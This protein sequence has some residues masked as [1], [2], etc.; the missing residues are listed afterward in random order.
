MPEAAEFEAY[1][2]R[3]Q[4]ER[5]ARRAAE[6][7]LEAKA[8]ELYD[9]NA[10][11]EAQVA[12]RT[13]DLVAA[14]DAAMAA[15]QARNG[16]F[17]R[18][19]HEI[20]TPMNAVIGMTDCMLLEDPPPSIFEGLT[21]VRSASQSLLSIINDI[22]DFSKIEA[23]GLSLQP[24]DFDLGAQFTSVT[25][26]L[27]TSAE[28]KGLSLAL[29]VDPRLNRHVHG[30]E[31]QLRQVLL[32]LVGNAIKFTGTGEVELGAHLMED[33][34]ATLAVE[35]WV[36]DTGSGI[37]EEDCG[38][39]FRAFEQVDG[40][41]TRAHGGT[42]LGLAICQSLVE[43]LGGEIWVESTLGEG[44]TFRF[45]ATLAAEG[46][47]RPVQLPPWRVLAL[48]SEPDTGDIVATALEG[49]AVTVAIEHNEMDV[50]Q[51]L[52]TAVAQGGAFDVVL[53][54]AQGL[55]AVSNLTAALSA[56]PTLQGV[57]TVVVGPSAARLEASG[58]QP[59]VS[60]VGTFDVRHIRTGLEELRDRTPQA[61]IAEPSE[62]LRRPARILVVDDN[63]TN[64]L[65][66]T[67]LLQR[68]G[69]IVQTAENGRDAVER[70]ACNRYDLVLMDVQMPGISGI[71]AARRI[72]NVE[73]GNGDGCKVPIVGFSAGTRAEDRNR[74][75]QGG[76]DGYLT[77]PVSADELYATVDGLQLRDLDV[78]E[79]EEGSETGERHAST[80][81]NDP[82]ARLR[83]RIS[84]PET[85][86]MLGDDPEIIAACIDAFVG[87]AADVESA[88]ADAIEASDTEAFKQV[89]HTL[90][91][92]VASVLGPDMRASALDLESAAACPSGADVIRLGEKLLGDLRATVHVFRAYQQ[93]ETG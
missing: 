24:V 57:S 5:T 18:M 47:S 6:Q 31:A 33:R 66:A 68:V 32:N 61:A 38:R 74:C 54:R 51:T 58:W 4:R 91:G 89:A 82:L 16:F 87:S 79:A 17:A 76:M 70:A 49:S 80:P 22:L 75:L 9:L 62:A 36:S 55:T 48:G 27:R 37:S 81:Q 23:G 3:A 77:K 46:A 39:I 93:Q 26:L 71:E 44:T 72:R 8:A 35:C 52:M 2:R 63:P 30:P 41:S 67:R 83:R 86:A 69:H 64:L 25:D 45:S 34:G 88:L 50:I 56:M 21:T 59:V 85:L 15:S 90:K 65:V 7:L 28:A 92:S 13:Q 40:S 14:L 84:E 42:G 20:R 53:I 60:E 12:D 11:L 19:S 29:S 43:A 1:K 73:V 10:S 78:V